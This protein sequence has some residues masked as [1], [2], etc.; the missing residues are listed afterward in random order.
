MSILPPSLDWTNLPKEGDDSF[1]SLGD[2]N[3]GCSIDS[4]L[5]SI[6]MYKNKNVKACTWHAYRM[7]S[8][9]SYKCACSEHKVVCGDSTGRLIARNY[10]EKIGVQIP[11][12]CRDSLGVLY[13]CSIYGDYSFLEDGV[14]KCGDMFV[15]HD[16][17]H[18]HKMNEIKVVDDGNGP[19]PFL[20]PG[21]NG[22]RKGTGYDVYVADGLHGGTYVCTYKDA[23]EVYNNFLTH[24][25]PRAKAWLILASH[26][27]GSDI[28]KL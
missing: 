16:C 1:G 3:P 28:P 6:S 21:I 15:C 26:M 17:I 23:I 11:S 18:M 20:P 2:H 14:N 5:C 24:D 10:C 7:G 27:P 13:C 4:T 8:F 12:A 19:V 9:E 25:D 22:I